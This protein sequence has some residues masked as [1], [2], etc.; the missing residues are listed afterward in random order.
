VPA[1]PVDVDEVHDVPL[2][3]PI[4]QVPGRAAQDQRESGARPAVSERQLR[5]VKPHADQ[6][7]EREHRHQRGLEREVR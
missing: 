2:P 3:R 6:R 4:E 5:G 7:P 1:T